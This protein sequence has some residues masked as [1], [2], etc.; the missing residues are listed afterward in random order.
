MRLPR[1]GSI[2]VMLDDEIERQKTKVLACLSLREIRFSIVHSLSVT[3]NVNRF[4]GATKC[5]AHSTVVGPEIRTNCSAICVLNWAT[6]QSR[7][8][9][10]G[11]NQK[12]NN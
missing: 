7:Q 8:H 10:N 11:K 3:S 9:K 4:G 2:V 6:H 12:I 1:S 5:N